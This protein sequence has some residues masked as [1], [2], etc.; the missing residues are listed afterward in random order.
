MTLPTTGD[1]AA[2]VHPPDA[3]RI[4]RTLT[5][6]FE[7]RWLPVFARALPEWVTPDTLTVIG[8]VASVL[9]G[10]G[11]WLSGLDPAWLWLV[12]FLVVVHWYGDS[13]DGT[14]ARVRK[15]ERPRY[16]FFV[17]HA[18]DSIAALCVCLGLG[19]SPHMDLRVAFALLLSYYLMMILVLL[20][21]YTLREFKI[22]YGRFGPTELRL[23]LIGANVALWIQNTWF[24]SDRLFTLWRVP[25][26]LMD[27]LA[28]G[29][30]IG[31]VITFLGAFT[32]GLARLARLEPPGHKRADAR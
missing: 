8:V 25:I 12:N 21:A 32:N 23:L 24:S 16:G 1:K 29:A 5:G 31:L 6:R 11:Y 19:L 14:L 20:N 7:R 10:V 26:R 22:S 2:A 15:I 27:L 13:L 9:I 28:I 30:G 18:A 4:I 17:D 3:K